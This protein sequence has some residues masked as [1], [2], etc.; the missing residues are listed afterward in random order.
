M[1][2][3]LALALSAALLATAA[4]QQA[5]NS[6]ATR[7]KFEGEV[8]DWQYALGHEDGVVIVKRAARGVSKAL[9]IRLEPGNIQVADIVSTSGLNGEGRISSKSITELIARSQPFDGYRYKC[10]CFDGASVEIMIAQRGKTTRLYAY[11]PIDGVKG[12][13]AS[14]I[15]AWEMMGDKVAESR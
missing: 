7:Q 5:A 9:F 14:V 8:S 2:F 11:G 6:A 3:H 12:P 1:S 13:A 10:L 15:R 4:P